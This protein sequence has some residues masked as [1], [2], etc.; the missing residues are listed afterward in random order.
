M[1]A[2]FI[3]HRNSVLSI[4]VGDFNWATA[5]NVRR[6]LNGLETSGARNR[7]EERRFEKTVATP[8]G[9]HEQYQNDFTHQS[10]SAW[11][12]L[13][14]IYC[15]QHVVE[16]LDRELR[17]T[18]LDWREDLSNHRAVGF[19]RKIP[20]E[21]ASGR[22]GVSEAAI[23]HVD[24]PRRARLALQDSLKDDPNC[25]SVERWHYH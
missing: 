3:V 15:N 23:K 20:D 17:V 25:S 4:A 16:Q 24:F 22:R 9:L 10:S 6:S 1:G 14:R 11:S 2:P 12:R 21:A 18:A 5:D 19:S 8:H 13:D 7:G